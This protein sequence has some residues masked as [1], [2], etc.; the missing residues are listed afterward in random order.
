MTT[1]EEMFLNSYTGGDCKELVNFD[2][3][4]VPTSNFAFG[5]LGK[6]LPRCTLWLLYA[7]PAHSTLHGVWLRVPHHHTITSAAQ[8]S[9]HHTAVLRRIWLR[10][11]PLGR[12]KG[13]VSSVSSG[14]LMPAVGLPFPPRT[15]LLSVMEGSMIV[16]SKDLPKTRAHLSLI[17]MDFSADTEHG[18]ALR[19]DFQQRRQ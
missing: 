10:P 19:K 3:G 16:S 13:P 4:L 11:Q 9:R 1:S 18:S 8:G 14:L 15:L 6:R 5:S 2:R 12:V 7:N 17:T